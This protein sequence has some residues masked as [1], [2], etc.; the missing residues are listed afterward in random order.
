MADTA[1]SGWLPALTALLGFVTASVLDWLRDRRAEQRERNAA[2]RTAAREREARDAARREQRFERRTAFQRQTLLD[3]QEATL[4]LVRATGE[5]NHLDTVASR[6]GGEWGKQ[7]FGEDLN[8]R[9]RLAQAQTTVLGVRVRDDA[10]RNGIKIVKNE[11][12]A[13]TSSRSEEEA[14]RAMHRMSDAF[15]EMNERLGEIL[16]KLDDDEDLDSQIA[17]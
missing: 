8:D 15:D 16:R 1:S 3:L 12:V 9:A 11:C 5:M 4:R 2:E 14:K 6:G 17:D 7:L 10:V 13:A